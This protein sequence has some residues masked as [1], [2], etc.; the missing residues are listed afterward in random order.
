MASDFFTRVFS[1]QPD[2]C[3]QKVRDNSPHRP[4]LYES[5]LAGVP[6]KKSVGRS[7]TP[8]SFGGSWICV[9]VEGDM[10][11]LLTEMNLD[12]Q[13]RDQAQKA[14]YGIGVQ[15]QRITQKMDV[16]VIENS[17]GSSVTGQFS[18]GSGT[19]RITDQNGKPSLIEAWWEDDILCVKNMDMDANI[20]AMTRRYRSGEQMVV[21]ITSRKGTWVRRTFENF[22]VDKEEPVTFLP[23]DKQRN[24]EFEEVVVASSRLE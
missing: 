6:P 17:L 4:F 1:C 23:S 3:T 12:S 21:E 16:F 2:C 24:S 8:P 20:T 22:D 14:R 15:V 5:V 9:E 19:Q 13:G 10:D 11:G 18:V 7:S